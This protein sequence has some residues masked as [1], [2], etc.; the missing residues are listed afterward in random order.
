[1]KLLQTVS[2]GNEQQTNLTVSDS[3]S[4]IQWHIITE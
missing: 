2:R 1:M 3:L 4:T